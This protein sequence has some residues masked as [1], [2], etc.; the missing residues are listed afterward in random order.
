M[1]MLGWAI[2][3][4]LAAILV[5]LLGFLETA[6]LAVMSKVLFWIFAAG[7]IFSLVMHVNRSRTGRH[8]DIKGLREH[9]RHGA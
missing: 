4:F 9:R 8:H 5:A 1:A 7:C 3:F 2:A 6:T